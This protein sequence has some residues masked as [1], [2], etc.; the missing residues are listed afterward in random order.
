MTRYV[1][2]PAVPIDPRSE[3][4]LVKEVSDY[5]V[6]RSQGLLTDFSDGSPLRAILEGQVF[7]FQE[8]LFYFNQLPEQLLT[9]WVAPFLGAQRGAGAAATVLVDVYLTNP[10]T[11]TFIIPAGYIVSAPSLGK[12]YELRQAILI[13]RG[14]TSGRGTFT[15]TT[16]GVSGNCPALS[17]TGF[18]N[19]IGV[20]R[21]ENPE[22]GFG[23]EDIETLRAAKER[24][25]S[26]IR[27]R[28]PVSEDDWKG[29]FQDL[30]GYGTTSFIKFDPYARVVHFRILAPGSTPLS[31][32][33]VSLAKSY[34]ENL[35]PAAYNLTL[36]SI[37]RNKVDLEVSVSYSSLPTTQKEVA[38]GIRDSFREALLRGGLPADANLSISDLNGYFSTELPKKFAGGK[39]YRNPD[40]LSIEAFAPPLGGGG[41]KSKDYDPTFSVKVGDLVQDSGS[42]FPV[43]QDFNPLYPSKSYYSISGYLRLRLVKA[44]IS[45]E[46]Y[47]VGDVI[48]D[49]GGVELR[50]A[51]NPFTASGDILTD[52]NRNYVS[53]SKSVKEWSIGERYSRGTDSSVGGYNPDLVLAEPSDFPSLVY[54]PS[55]V[56]VHSPI[57]TVEK[58]FVRAPDTTDFGTLQSSG[59]VSSTPVT[60]TAFIYGATYTSGQYLV[61]PEALPGQGSYPPNLHYIDLELGAIQRYYV[62]LEGFEHDSTTG[63]MA[64]DLKS[65]EEFGYIRPITATTSLFPQKYNARFPIGKYLTDGRGNNFL[66]AT[67]FTPFTLD[68][69]TYVSTGFLVEVSYIPPT[70]VEP[71][72]RLNPG[73][74]TKLVKGNRVVNYSIKRSFTPVLNPEAY[75]HLLEETTSNI[76]STPFFDSDYNHEDILSDE[77]GDLF[78]VIRPFSPEGE[79]LEELASLGYVQRLVTSTEAIQSGEDSVSI[80]GDV[81]VEVKAEGQPPSSYFVSEGGT[82][83][84]VPAFF[85]EAL[86]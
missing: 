61:T 11:D 1:P 4:E 71:V 57:W 2:I 24:F 41:G 65:Y 13:P 6:S 64:A 49:P 83:P 39:P 48:L 23:G 18:Q 42:M 34:L 67:P 59:L 54:F 60:P 44:Y 38:Q 17:V 31:P 43:L 25:F 46:S 30:F 33:E 29:L 80:P 19:I 22:P 51:L 58:S 85:G 70:V 81:L 40:I 74:T 62:V 36:D 72:F 50:V 78:K 28:V 82:I 15:C 56:Q 75:L 45:G 27:R 86:F 35:V 79:S 20:E 53:T 21:V 26:L 9:E 5:I 68:V 10:A 32:G 77:E 76:N 66:V 3:R 69:D 12:E 14:T 63:D 52:L 84:P 7:A 16:R 55:G 8:Y 47:S 37:P 73:S